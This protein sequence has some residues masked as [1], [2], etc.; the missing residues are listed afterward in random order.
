MRWRLKGLLSRNT[1]KQMVPNLN[2]LM[3]CGANFWLAIVLLLCGCLPARLA[4]QPGTATEYSDAIAQ[5]RT[6]LEKI[7]TEE[8]YFGISVSV[9]V[10]DSIVYAE[11]FGFA[12]LE[13]Q[14]AATPDHLF[15]IYSIAKAMTG[16]ALAKLWED[17]QIDLDAP[18]QTYLPSL[19]PALRD[20]TA[21]QLV[22]H[23]SGVRHYREGEWLKV[24]QNTCSSPL[25]GLS[26]F[27]ADSL[28]HA[29]GQRFTYSSFGYVLLS[30]VIEAAAGE[31]FQAY[32]ARSIFE[33]AGMTAIELDNPTRELPRRAQPYEYWQETIYEARFANNTCKMGGGGFVASSNDVARFGLALANHR[34]VAPETRDLILTSMQE[35]SGE[36]T[37]YGFGIGVGQDEEDG[38]FYAVHSGGAIGGRAA[39]FLYPQDGV[40]VAITANSNGRRLTPDAEIIAKLF[41]P[42]P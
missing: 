22:G 3:R 2:D 1:G 25:D 7:L 24:S 5:T 4:A 41:L 33:P 17:G 38:R 26:V 15:R 11:G 6:I 18:V 32:M 27:E 19:K 30:A 14:E 10:G 31:P 42:P 21:R 20:V 16:T 36:E 37:E 23:L 12:Q 39:L 35:Q 28:D 29:S 40:V 8:D 13:Q 9:G 34:L